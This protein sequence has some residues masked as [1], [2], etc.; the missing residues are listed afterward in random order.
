MKNKK[1]HPREIWLNEGLKILEKR[2]PSGLTIDNLVLGTGKTKGSFYHHF[3]NRSNYIEA[4][5]SYYETKATVEI[6]HAVE[7]E[8]EQIA[9]LKKLTELVFQISSELE[10]VIRAWSLYEP[11]VKKFQERI[12]Q[13]RLDHMVKIY[14]TPSVELTQAQ[15]MALRNYAIYI[16]LQQLKH[17]HDDKKIQR[18]FKRYLY[19][20]SIKVFTKKFNL[21]R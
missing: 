21:I 17:I 14:H 6:L 12:D 7:K 3:K 8:S 10:L 20:A 9:R 1:I 2:G 16:G 19:Y 5:M 13:K 11:V 4:L 18:T 15:I